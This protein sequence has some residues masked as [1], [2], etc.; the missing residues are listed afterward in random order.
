M[1]SDIQ[2]FLTT[3]P[4][5]KNVHWNS[6]NAVR[7]PL[8]HLPNTCSSQSLPGGK[9]LG[10]SALAPFLCEWSR[11]HKHPPDALQARDASRYQCAIWSVGDKCKF[12]VGR[13][14]SNVMDSQQRLVFGDVTLASTLGFC[15]KCPYLMETHLQHI[16]QICSA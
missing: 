6:A 12:T 7:R 16:F 9:S 4:R 2:T 3:E 14:T 1:L 15:N 13:G 11:R 8:A 5:R 10:C